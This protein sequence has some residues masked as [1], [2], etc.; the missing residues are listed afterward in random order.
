MRFYSYRDCGGGTV[1]VHLLSAPRDALNTFSTCKEA[2][3]CAARLEALHPQIRA[4]WD[5]REL[6][7]LPSKTSYGTWAVHLSDSYCNFFW[8]KRQAAEFIKALAA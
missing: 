6:T 7:A 2:E 5:R 1:E 8:S 4:V 3:L